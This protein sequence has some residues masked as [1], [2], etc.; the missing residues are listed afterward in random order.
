MSPRSY[1]FGEFDQAGFVSKR[2][3]AM[4]RGLLFEAAKVLLSRTC[5]PSHLKAGEPR[6]G[7][8]IEEGDDGGCPQAGR[9]HA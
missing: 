6:L 2:G 4:V 9:D 7:K 1:Q 5:W 8:R 3:E